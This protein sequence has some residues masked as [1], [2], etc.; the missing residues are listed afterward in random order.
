MVDDDGTKNEQI[1]VLETTLAA[2]MG[3]KAQ[4]L[5]AD[6]HQEQTS[7][8][9]GKIIVRADA[10]KDSNLEYQFSFVWNEAGNI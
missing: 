10:V 8:S 5:Q 2:I 7:K 9:Q 6:L 4:N 3:S 1:G